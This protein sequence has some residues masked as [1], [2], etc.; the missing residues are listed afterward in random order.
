MHGT[1]FTS[2]GS[3]PRVKGR[4]LGA[5]IGGKRVALRVG[6]EALPTPW[7]FFFFL[8]SLSRPTFHLLCSC[9]PIFIPVSLFHCCPPSLRKRENRESSQGSRERGSAP[10]VRGWCSGC[11][12][13]RQRFQHRL[14]F[15]AGWPCGSWRFLIRVLTPSRL[16]LGPRARNRFPAKRALSK[17]AN[18]RYAGPTKPSNRKREQGRVE[19]NSKKKNARQERGWR[20]RYARPPAGWNW[21]FSLFHRVLYLTSFYSK[22]LLILSFNNELFKKLA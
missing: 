16:P 7:G 21:F 20:T 5:F 18:E 11:Q 10:A 19:I 22:F 9:L 13:N 1:T 14:G 2:E 6:V 15:Q 17:V 12:D 8:L 4:A 3:E